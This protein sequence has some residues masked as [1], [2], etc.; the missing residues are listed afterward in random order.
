MNM[1][2][3][4]EYVVIERH[5]N[6]GTIWVGETG[7][8]AQIR[9]YLKNSNIDYIW[10]ILELKKDGEIVNEKFLEIDEDT[11]EFIDNKI[12]GGLIEN[13]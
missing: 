7:T 10:N 9:K 11:N 4:T 1:G 2:K 5:P 3:E 8:D 13:E 12:V 6:G